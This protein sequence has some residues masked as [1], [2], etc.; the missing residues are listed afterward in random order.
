MD[1]RP[2]SQRIDLLGKLYVTPTQRK[3]FL[4]WSLYTLTFLAVLVVQ[5][6]IFSRFLLPGGKLDLVPVALVLVC[7]LEGTQSG[8]TFVLLCTLVYLFS[9]SAPGSYVI[10]FLTAVGMVAAALRWGYLRKTFSAV[11]LC[12]ALGI[13]LYEM[14]L[15]GAGLLL[16]RTNPGRAMVFV[17]TGLWSAGTVPILYPV[18]R[19]IGTIGGESWKE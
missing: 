4:K 13:M 11:W 18:L 1:F 19:A 5:D 12:T 16:G 7:V 6:V 17:F 9:G 14:V 8:G 3:R 15:F 10:A 2:D